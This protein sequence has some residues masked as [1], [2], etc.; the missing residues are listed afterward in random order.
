LIGV[1]V[2]AAEC[3]CGWADAL[4]APSSPAASATAAVAAIRGDPRR[5]GEGAL[6]R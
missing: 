6:T 4:P 2:D 1:A 3:A 5:T